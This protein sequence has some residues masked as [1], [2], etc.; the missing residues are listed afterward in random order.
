MH[1]ALTFHLNLRLEFFSPNNYK[2]QL[3]VTIFFPFYGP[4]RVVFGSSFLLALS[5]LNL[6][7]LLKCYLDT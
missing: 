3:T 6:L 1:Y 5:N 2:I 7:L 4:R